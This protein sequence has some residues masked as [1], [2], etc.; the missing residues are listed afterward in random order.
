MNQANPTSQTL[1]VRALSQ[2]FSEVF[3]TSTANLSVDKLAGDASTRRYY[4]IRQNSL[5]GPTWILQ[6]SEPFADESKSSHPFL[7]AQRLLELLKI[8]VP[9]VLGVEASQGWVLLE[10][11]GDE[12]LQNHPTMALYKRALDLLIK[13][14][15][16]AEVNNP[17][18]AQI[19]AIAPH[20]KWAFDFEKLQFEMGFTAQHLVE[21]FL[22]ID[23]VSFL[24]S[25]ATNSQYLSDAP[26]FFCHRDFHSRNLMVSKT[27]EIWAID[28]QDAR[29][30]PLTY[31]LVSLLWDPYVRL[32][33][34]W[35]TEL[36]EY[37]HQNLLEGALKKGD[38][39]LIQF[40]RD[41]SRPAR[42]EVEMQRMKIQR[43]L[44][45]AGSYA[46]F[47]NNKGRTD[48]LPSIEPALTDTIEALKWLE[49]RAREFTEHDRELL[50]HVARWKAIL[51]ANA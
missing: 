27:G 19:S 25:V 44:K 6:I 15:L 7:A 38:H 30:G 20:F 4:R 13:W 23:S 46:S 24:K 26:R 32:G 50:M 22:K 3:C 36:L 16:T 12:T 33:D 21:K 28:F 10:D 1:D 31:D 18:L 41:T 43:L 51:P 5:S 8:P 35:R 49:A 34:K 2:T 14:T 29:M 48:Y 42:W 17:V 11:L 40:L 9:K 45:A 47:F 37:W 39:A